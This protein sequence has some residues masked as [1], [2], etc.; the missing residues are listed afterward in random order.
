[1]SSN[2][3]FTAAGAFAFMDRYPVVRLGLDAAPAG[4]PPP[5]PPGPRTKGSPATGQEI[6]SSLQRVLHMNIGPEGGLGAAV[7]TLHNEIPVRIG[8]RASA[9]GIPIFHLPYNNDHNFRLT[10][11]DKQG[12]NPTFFLTEI[13]DGCSIYVEGTPANP[14][15][16]HVN[17]VGQGTVP[18]PARYTPTWLTDWNVRFAHMDGRFANDPAPPRAGVMGPDAPRKP[19]RVATGDPNLAPARKLENPDYMFTAP[20]HEGAF[21]GT[22][23][24]LAGNRVPASIGGLSVDEMEVMSTQGT[25][26]GFSVGGLWSFHV[27]KRVLVTHYHFTPLPHPTMARTGIRGA[28]DT[29]LARPP[30]L[31]IGPAPV[32]R[33]NLGTQWIIRAVE[34]FWPNATTGRPA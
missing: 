19:K 7:R 25:V 9:P 30:P 5:P 23:V 22:L 26:F 20:A 24:A 4:P 2:A 33:V 21:T 31:A 3:I 11:T 18:R 12:L 16:Y 1:M 28:V 14:T 8:L 34:E 29:L 6:V 17:A 10:L 13:V 15:V 27:Q 32:Q